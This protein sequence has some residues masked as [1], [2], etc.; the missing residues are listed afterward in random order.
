[1]VK[2][3]LEFTEFSKFCQELIGNLYG[4]DE[5]SDITLIG[6]DN[7][8]FKA[9]KF[10]LRA[11]SNVIRDVLTSTDIEKPLLYFKGFN[12]HD[13]KLLLDFMYLGE[14]SCEPK[15]VNVFFKTGKFLQIK[16]LVEECE[17]DGETIHERFSLEVLDQFCDIVGDREVKAEEINQME[18]LPM[19]NEFSEEV[20]SKE[21]EISV[22]LQFGENE[23]VKTVV[24][25]VCQTFLK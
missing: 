25:L 10:V 16:Q 17:D 11:H 21:K 23:N 2:C 3:N 20:G 14:T 24:I 12:G 1:M 7:R 4:S 9:H 5:F 15:N 22:E 13:I 8:Q 6:D 19:E 18:I